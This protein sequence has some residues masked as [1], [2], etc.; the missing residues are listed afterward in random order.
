MTS[1]R[2]RPSR[3]HAGGARRGAP[4]ANARRAAVEAFERTLGSLS[5]AELALE[6]VER[7]LDERD[8]RFARELLFGALR[9]KRRLETV[10]ERASERSF[11]AIDEPLRAVLVVAAVQLLLLDRVPAHAAVSEAVEE[12]RRRRGGGASGFV[13]A[14]LR[15]I[16]AR[17]RL[18]DWPIVET[19]PRLRLAIETSHPDR[20]VE[21]W[22]D[23]FGPERTRRLLESSNAERPI[24]LLAFRDRG[25]REAASRDLAAE[26]CST[27]PSTLAPD[28][29]V[30][31]GGSPFATEAF[32]RG[33]IY[34]QDEA[35]QAAALVPAPRAGE[36]VYDAA[37]APGGKGLALVANEPAV[38]LIS[39]DISLRRIARLRENHARL[40]RAIPI[41]A[42]DA[43]LPPAGAAFDR[44]VLDAP[45]S[46]SG[47]LRRHP[48]L[49]W[50]FRESELERLGAAAL[51]QLRALAD[52]VAPGGALVHVT[53]SIEPE[54]N[55][56]VA[57]RFLIM[58]NDFAPAPLDA[59]SV[60]GGDDALSGATGSDGR[61][62][63]L[64]EDGHDG[65]SVA[66]FR[67]IR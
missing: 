38:R 29:L 16:A 50:R 60:P 2:K 53:C 23:R 24:H 39:A 21:R 26:G 54:E 11:E 3:A 63:V 41:V 36:R 9:W 62:R 4:P 37:A 48:E 32:R 43:E 31:L 15:R 47:T 58:R 46:G 66:V 55:E 33:A 35:S 67:R 44:V 59:A 10:V 57:A 1:P 34:V 13:N 65:F 7:G 28:G 52:L 45:C 51:A 40:G 5:P 8:R 17:P 27:A 12:A 6:R 49:K 20:L 42:A 18:E 14:V 30:V 56:E 25:G 61:W 19:D 22:W 64:P